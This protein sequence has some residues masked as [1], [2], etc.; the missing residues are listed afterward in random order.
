MCCAIRARWEARP[1]VRA[2]MSL[3]RADGAP[4]LAAG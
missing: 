4:A 2:F 3:L 1:A